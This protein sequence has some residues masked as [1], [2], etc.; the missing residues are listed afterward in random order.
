MT[1][2]DFSPNI[3]LLFWIP[4]IL[5]IMIQPIYIWFES[6]T[7]QLSTPFLY[8]DSSG[9]SQARGRGSQ[10]MWTDSYIL[11]LFP[12]FNTIILP[13]IMTTIWYAHWSIV[14]PSILIEPV[15]RL[16]DLSHHLKNSKKTLKM[17]KTPINIWYQTN[18]R[19]Y[20]SQNWVL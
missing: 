3:K 13:L 14:I 9:A 4:K 20:T 17:Y 16:M 2:V 12:P 11:S 7:F 10:L 1:L 5:F 18:L 8:P 15:W 19:I 6:M